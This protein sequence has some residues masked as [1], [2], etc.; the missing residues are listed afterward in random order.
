MAPTYFRN[1]TFLN[2]IEAGSL[3]QLQNQQFVLLDDDQFVTAPISAR[4]L[5]LPIAIG[6]ATAP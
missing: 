3:W 6:T 1:T 5:F 4:N 2:G